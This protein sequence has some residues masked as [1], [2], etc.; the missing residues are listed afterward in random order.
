MAETEAKGV[1]YFREK[2]LAW[3]GLWDTA[4]VW[5]DE[6]WMLECNH[7]VGGIDSRVVW[8]ELNW[9]RERTGADEAEAL[10]SE[11]HYRHLMKKEM[12]AVKKARREGSHRIVS[13]FRISC[14][15]PVCE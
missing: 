11:F 6:R 15:K 7:L 8:R 10:K 3:I 13:H 4:A 14:R 2:S 5:W 1:A 9:L 12:I